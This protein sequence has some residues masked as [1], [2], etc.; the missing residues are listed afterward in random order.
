MNF[1]LDTLLTPIT[2]LAGMLAFVSGCGCFLWRL[3]VYRARSWRKIAM[4]YA[5]L[6]SRYQ[7]AVMLGTEVRPRNLN[8][9]LIPWRKGRIPMG[10]FWIDSP[11]TYPMFSRGDVIALG[12]GFDHAIVRVAHV[13]P[14]GIRV[15]ALPVRS[16]YRKMV[17]LLRRWFGAKDLD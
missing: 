11:A 2:A 12:S 8:L 3:S 7:E 13:L 15:Q 5:D 14:D 6:A 16:L 1:D 9:Q 17:L 10:E 4:D